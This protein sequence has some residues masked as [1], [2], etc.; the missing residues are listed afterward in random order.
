MGKGAKFLERVPVNKGKN[1]ID[2]HKFAESYFTPK[3]LYM[4][5]EMEKCLLTEDRKSCT[6]SEKQAHR[7]G[8]FKGAFQSFA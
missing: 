3:R 2:H 5:H 6:K 4:Q 7:D 8:I 1:L